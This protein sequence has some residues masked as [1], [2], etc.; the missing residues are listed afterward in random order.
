MRRRNQRILMALALIVLSFVIGVIAI[1]SLYKSTPDW[2]APL[3]VASTQ[4]SDIARGAENKLTE[5]H[6]WA[7][8]VNAGAT[9]TDA[10]EITLSQSEIDELMAK[11]S[12]L[13]TSLPHYDE[14][15]SD[16]RLV[17]R[18][19][20][21]IL[22]GRTP[23]IGAVTSVHLSPSL[24]DNGKLQLQIV[25]VMAGRLPLPEMLWRSQRQRLEE[26]LSHEMARWR[27]QARTNRRSV[28]A[29]AAFAGLS[30][31]LIDSLENRAT[32][33][34]IYLPLSEG[35][36]ALPVR[37]TKL[38]VRDRDISIRFSKQPAQ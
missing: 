5:L 16:A 3:A 38:Q 32:E 11:W 36:K 19:G 8:R 31:L 25:K 20:R 33:P 6:N 26:A 14:Y 21:I 23:D 27:S 24:D 2:Y 4:S 15:V 17:I 35:G 28:N 13:W 1:F 7:Q 37:V 10:F 34:V 9:S 22:V 18:D 12:S 29:A 30:Q